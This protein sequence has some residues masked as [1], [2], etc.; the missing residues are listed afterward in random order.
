MSI[1]RGCAL[2]LLLL[3]FAPHFID[4]GLVAI[5]NLVFRTTQAEIHLEHRFERSPVAVV[6]DHRGPKRVLKRFAIL[7]RDVLNC[8]HCVQVFR[9][10]D[11]NPRVAKFDNETGEQVK[12][13][14]ARRL[15]VDAEFLR[16]LGNIGLILQ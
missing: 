6:L 5:N 1:V 2:A 8:L 10:R 16:G 13:G 15:F 14:R 3:H 4:V 12:H 11:G 7:D 9:Q